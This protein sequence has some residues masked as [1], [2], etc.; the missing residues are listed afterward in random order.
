[1][2]PPPS[3]NKTQ[4]LTKPP[5]N[6]IRFNC[7]ACSGPL[8]A[9]IAQAGNNIKCPHCNAAISIPR[10]PSNPYSR[11]IGTIIRQMRAVT[12]AFPYF[13]QLIQVVVLSVVIA[14]LA[15]LFITVGLAAQI[16]G[17]F[18]GLI[19]DAQKHMREGSAVESSAQAIS[20]GLYLLFILPFWIV[21]FPFSF[22]GSLWSSRN[23]GSLILLMLLAAAAIAVRA[24]WPQ[25]IQLRNHQ[26]P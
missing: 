25:I 23:F 12:I 10:I 20:I 22:I 18:E 19:V 24:Y 21:Q 3:P 9:E 1:M 26:A 14:I 7:L 4:K 16:C 2:S 8:E 6:T 15:I 5:K 17:I 13:P 11:P